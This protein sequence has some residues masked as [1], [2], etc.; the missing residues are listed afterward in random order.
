MAWLLYYILLGIYGA[1]LVFALGYYLSRKAPTGDASVGWAWGLIYLLGL[2]GIV[3][4]ALLLRNHQSFGLVVL[5]LPMLF[6]GW[7]WVKRAR[8]EWYIRFPAFTDT[9]ALTLF[10]ENNTKS[11]L[12]IRLDCWFGAAQS[13]RTRLFTNFDYYVE[14]STETHFLLDAR[15]T[16]LVAHKSKYVGIEIFE[17]ITEKYEGGTYTRD[18][19]PCMKILEEQPEAFRSGVY[20]LVIRAES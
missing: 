3:V 19:Q 8:T 11:A 10:I 13:H 17:R 12:H 16:R 4:L 20:R 15:Q 7:P 2:A 14:P 18:I 1:V 5:C 6:L 9:P